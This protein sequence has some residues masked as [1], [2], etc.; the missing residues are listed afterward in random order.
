MRKINRNKGLLFVAVVLVVTLACSFP[1]AEVASPLETEPPPPTDTS[2][3]PAVPTDTPPSPTDTGMPTDTVE[4]D[5]TTVCDLAGFIDDVT[6]PDGSKVDPGQNFT[7]TWRLKNIGS[8]TWT[9]DYR[10]VFSSGDQMGAPAA[11]QFTNGTVLPGAE[12]D[13]S[14]NLTAP[15]T[16][17]T[18]KGYFKLRNANSVIFALAGNNPFWVEVKVKSPASTAVVIPDWPTLKQGNSGDEVAALQY[19][20]KSHGYSLTADGVFGPSTRSA[21][22]SFQS[23]KGLS[24]DGIVGKNTWSALI[25]GKTVKTGNTGDAVKAAQY[26]LANKFGY[27]L[28]ID[29]V[30]GSGT[31]Q[32]VRDFQ[33]TYGLSADGIVGPDTWKALISL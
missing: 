6:V 22:Q 9:A 18:Y 28:T 29:G 32:A 14:V 25:S 27:S 16:P 24:V 12:V 4:P 26:L 21:V 33:S 11:V 17:D 23:S 20:L 2:Q 30:F 3:S 8:C 31:N 7:K 1:G 19:L 10:L 15:N 13:V 5:A